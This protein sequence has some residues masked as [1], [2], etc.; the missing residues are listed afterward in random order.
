MFISI[1]ITSTQYNIAQEPILLD[2]P[3]IACL[4]KSN[5]HICADTGA[6]QSSRSIRIVEDDIP[7]WT[8][9]N[10]WSHYCELDRWQGFP[11]DKASVEHFRPTR[12]SHLFLT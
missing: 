8:W 10:R 5:N 7:D 6:V 12:A 1:I 11:G 3:T 4:H 9:T 2:S